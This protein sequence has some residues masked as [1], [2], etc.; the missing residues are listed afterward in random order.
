MNVL[1]FSIIAYIKSL[2]ALKKSMATDEKY[3]ERLKKSA[4]AFETEYGVW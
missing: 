3:M 1:I 4:E 2:V